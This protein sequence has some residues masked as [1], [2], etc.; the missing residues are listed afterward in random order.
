MGTVNLLSN[1]WKSDRGDNTSIQITKASEYVEFK[2]S[3]SAS[4]KIGSAKAYIPIDASKY[5]SVTL[6]YSKISHSGI[7]DINFGI[8]NTYY[9][10]SDSI[11]Y[12]NLSTSGGTITLNI[13]SSTSGT[14]YVG[15]WFYGNAYEGTARDKIYVTSLTAVERGYTLTYD[16]NGGTDGPSSV[17]DI[18]STT[19]SSTVPTRSGYD[20]LGWST[21]SKETA[22]SYVAEN[23]ISLSSNVTLYA[24]WRKFYTVTYDANGGSN[25]PSSGKKINEQ[26]LTLSTSAPTP[27]TNT[28]VTHTIT[29]NANGGTCDKNIVT[30]DHDVTYKFNNW[31]TESDGSGTTYQPGESYTTDSDITLYAQ[32]TSTTTYNSVTLPTPFR[33]NYYFLGWSTNDYDTSGITGE[34]TPH[35]DIVLYATWKIK[36]QVYICDKL[37]GF[38]PY[39]VLIYD[40]SDWNQYV[41]YIYTYSGWEIYSG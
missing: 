2:I 22:A 32:Y 24:V 13:P 21:S 12:V 3:S 16:A 28:S 36:G 23:T 39:K 31:N 11:T 6:K 27:P 10:D 29:L 7:T 37:D 34:Y 4:R 41:P 8:Y 38:S 30:V 5:S 20:F 33:E 26:T 35:E 18:T 40:G 1:G 14:K 9:P 15:F 19:I 17:T 25:A